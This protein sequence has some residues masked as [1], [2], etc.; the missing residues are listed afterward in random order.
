MVDLNGSLELVNYVFSNFISTL[1]KTLN[2]K[3]RRPRSKDNKSWPAQVF[4][5]EITF[6]VLGLNEGH[7]IGRENT[8]DTSTYQRC[9]I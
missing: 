4:I 8:H 9:K 7:L 5:A 1:N 2:S 3:Y 6:I